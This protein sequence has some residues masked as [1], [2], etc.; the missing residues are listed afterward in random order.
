MPKVNTIRPN[1]FMFFKN[2]I[3]ILF[4]PPTCRP[5]SPK[6]PIRAVKI[7]RIIYQTS[8]GL[9]FRTTTST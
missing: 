9:I 2:G 8:Q 5:Q 4:W 7:L 3:I 1:R 6:A